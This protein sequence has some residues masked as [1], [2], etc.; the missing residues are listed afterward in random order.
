[1]PD[2]CYLLDSREHCLL[3]FSQERTRHTHT[4]LADL[5]L[6]PPGGGAVSSTSPFWGLRSASCSRPFIENC[7]AYGVY[8][9]PGPDPPGG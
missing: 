6:P 2:E 4:A 7:P 1:M 5:Q 3:T 8:A 9:P